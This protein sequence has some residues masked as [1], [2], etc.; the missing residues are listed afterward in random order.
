V[1]SPLLGKVVFDDKTLNAKYLRRA[2]RETVGFL[3]ALV[4]AEAMSIVAPETMWVEIG[5][6][7]VCCAFVK[8]TLPATTVAVP[9]L[10]RGEDNWTTLAQSLG[11]LH[12]AGVDVRWS[13][14]HR[15][16][17]GALSLLD[18]P[19]YSW[20][21]K[22]HWIQYNGNW[23]L[24]KGNTFYDAEKGTTK[25]LPAPFPA[26]SL[27]TSTVQQIIEETVEGSSGRVVMQSDLMQ[28]DFL[29]AAH[30]HNMNGCGVVTSVCSLS[31]ASAAILTE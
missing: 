29:A 24:T 27:K 20:N 10:R 28:P 18:L 17:E 8:A 22:T 12:R 30:G 16:F 13:E 31:A 26:S 6:H 21:N 7:P 2:T 19:T 15:P 1:I 3:P 4:K 14:F 25:T 23:A 5:P 9:S 11:V